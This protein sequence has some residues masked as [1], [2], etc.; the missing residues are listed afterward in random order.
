[1][2]N[3]TNIQFQENLTFHLVVFTVHMRLRTNAV[4][5]LI[6]STEDKFPV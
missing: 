3:D 1:V 5:Q 6:P 2:Y 4:L